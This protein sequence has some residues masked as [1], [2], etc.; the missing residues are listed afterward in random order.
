VTQIDLLITS[1]W[2]LPVDNDQSILENHAV[3]VIKDTVVEI[4]PADKLKARY[5]ATQSVDLPDHALIP[6]LVNAHTHAAMTLFRGYA[7]DIP[8]ME[9]LNEHIWPAESR[10]VDEKFVQ[11]GTDLAC[12]EMIKGGTT[13]FN[14]M[15][16][17]P[18]IVAKRTEKAGMRA[19]IGMIVVDFPTVWAQNADEYINKGLEVRD[20]IRHSNLLTAAFAPHAPYT[21]SDQ[22]LQKIATLSDELDC[23]V[24][25]H[26]HETA[27]EIEQS[28][29]RF[30]MRPIERLDQLG[31]VGPRLIAVHMTQLLPGEIETLAER[32]I[33]VAHCPRSNLKLASGFCEVSKITESGINIALGTDSA[34][35]NN[36]LDMISEMM[37]ASLLAKGVSG[38]PTAMNAYSTLEA[39]TMG[40]AR[41]LGLEEKIGSI[42]VGKQA[43]LCAVDMSD[44]GSQPV[45]NPVSQLVY[46]ASSRQVSDVWV[47]W[48]RLLESGQLTT[49]DEKQVKADTLEWG[50]RIKAGQ[51]QDK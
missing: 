32:G 50:N 34:S 25:I 51:R 37:T 30:G 10:W 44:M 21:V 27:H 11:T 15:Y 28:M 5:T 22:P 45:Y 43:D 36:T 12:A 17:F 35:S 18:D 4:G 42:E 31:L 46:S 1:R 6:G 7:D 24:H 20:S 16:F 29:A 48:A 14:D 19:C 3:A 8:L 23:P 39:A 38:S 41:A 2:L 33:H 47:A 13:C 26:L 49:I 40:G 9:W